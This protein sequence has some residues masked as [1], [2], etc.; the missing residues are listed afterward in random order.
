MSGDRPLATY[1]VRVTVRDGRR[2]I[3][4]LVVGSGERS[5]FSSYADL[6]EYLERHEDALGRRDA[7]D[8]GEPP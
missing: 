1:L 7:S 4:L 8:V 6:L 2:S 5:R 3:G